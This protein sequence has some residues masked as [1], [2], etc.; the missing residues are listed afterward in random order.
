MWFILEQQP[1]KLC[2]VILLYSQIKQLCYH[3]KQEHK[4]LFFPWRWKKKQTSITNLICSN[5]ESIDSIANR[6]V[7][8]LFESIVHSKV[9]DNILFYFSPYMI[10]N[11]VKKNWL[12]G[13]CNI[14]STT[15]NINQH[16]YSVTPYTTFLK[17]ENRLAWFK[18]RMTHTKL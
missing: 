7:E 11:L 2:Y 17:L 1:N 12:S 15:K 10:Y 4:F 8:R 18:H 14:N 5:P 6:N 3:L 13:L 16:R 9:I